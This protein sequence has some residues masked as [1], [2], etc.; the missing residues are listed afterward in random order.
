MTSSAL[1]LLLTGLSRAAAALA[2]GGGALLLAIV[3]MTAANTLAFAADGL[4]RPF[5]GAVR[6]LSG[7]EDAARLF[8]GCA[9][10]MFLP[11]CQLKRGHI[12]VTLLS[13]GLAPRR[14]RALDVASVVLTARAAGVLAQQMVIGLGETRLDGVRSRVLGWSEWPFYLPGVVALAL[15][16][17]VAAAQAVFS[18]FGQVGGQEG[19][20][21]GAEP[22]QALQDPERAHPAPERRLSAPE[23]RLPAPERRL[24][25]PGRRLSAPERRRG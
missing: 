23:R 8:I 6:G 2:L 10:P 5:G 14:T 4:A 13:S 21:E 9:A 17:A 12:R 16:S 15:W 3:A 22:E 1:Q 20:Q 7:Y 24:S 19:G 25:A 11:Y 18:D